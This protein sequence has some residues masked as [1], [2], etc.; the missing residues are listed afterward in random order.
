MI[1]GQ[2]IYLPDDFSINLEYEQDENKYELEVEIKWQ[3]EF[4]RK[5]TG[6]FELF[7]GTNDQ[8]YFHLKAPNGEI[9]LASEGYKTKQGAETL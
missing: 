8:W 6:K 4:S 2:E 9:I 5:R 1:D 3:K 7:T